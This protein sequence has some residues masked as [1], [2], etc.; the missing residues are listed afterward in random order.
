MPNLSTYVAYFPLSFTWVSFSMLLPPNAHSGHLTDN[1]WHISISSV[2]SPLTHLYFSSLFIGWLHVIILVYLLSKGI[3]T[4]ETDL[5]L[6]ILLSLA[7]EGILDTEYRFLV[8]MDPGVTL[9]LEWWSQRWWAISSRYW[10]WEQRLWVP[11]W[12]ESF[13]RNKPGRSWTLKTTALFKFFLNW[14]WLLFVF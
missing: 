13:Q 12:W 10:Q 11:K 3:N 9:T 6:F 4:K 5:I 1:K 2:S 8:D 7:P 14:N